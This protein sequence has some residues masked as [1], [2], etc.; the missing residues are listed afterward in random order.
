MHKVYHCPLLMTR[1]VAQLIHIV[2][3]DCACTYTISKIGFEIFPKLKGV[4]FEMNNKFSSYVRNQFD[5]TFTKPELWSQKMFQ[6]YVG[7]NF[8]SHTSLLT[9]P[10][11]SSPLLHSSPP[12]FCPGV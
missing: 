2:V 6:N 7:S 8:F 1:L 4:M 3:N 11:L 9:Q 12:G 5:T 10:F